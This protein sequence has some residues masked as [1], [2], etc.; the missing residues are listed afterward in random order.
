MDAKQTKKQEYK[1]ASGGNTKYSRLIY[2]QKNRN[3]EI[4][5][6]LDASVLLRCLVNIFLQKIR[7][8]KY[9][10][11]LKKPFDS[12]KSKGVSPWWFVEFFS[13]PFSDR[14]LQILI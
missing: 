2:T 5:D 6:E 4:V 13:I 12:A 9:M 14:Y 8:S 7:G 10:Q 3:I 11:T 1:K